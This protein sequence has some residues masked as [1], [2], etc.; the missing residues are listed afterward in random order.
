MRSCEE[1]T[2]EVFRR[3]EEQ[4]A[5]QTAARKRKRRRFA[6]TVSAACCFCLAV[7]AGVGV[8]RIALRTVPSS[9]T[10]DQS[11]QPSAASEASVQTSGG[12]TGDPQ[13]RIDF[14]FPA[15]TDPGEFVIDLYRPEG[16]SEWIGSALALKMELSE[17]ENER[18]RVIVSHW[19]RS[20]EE[21]IAEVNPSLSDPID[22]T[23]F[24][25]VNFVDIID[26]DLIPSDYET[27]LHHSPAYY[28]TLTAAQI[29]ALANSQYRIRCMYVGSGEGDRRD[30]GWDTPEGINIYC[31][32]LGDEMVL[33]GDHIEVYWEL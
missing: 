9:E 31:E 15:R 28:G 8:W 32:L 27:S 3:I 10:P 26:P 24:R 18:F 2:A 4:R 7:L 1:M 22:F 14:Y 29:L 33:V 13:K 20:L 25:T 30:A 5:A 11:A 6:R 17:D 21:V 23:A 12:P 19:N 16:Y